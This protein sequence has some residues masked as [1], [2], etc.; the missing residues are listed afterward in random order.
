M[1]TLDHS[2][3]K[4]GQLPRLRFYAIATIAEQLNVSQRTVLRRIKSGELVAHH[5]GRSVRVSEADL[6]LFLAAHRDDE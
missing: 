2:P 6:K 3:Q 4:A 1:A 5:F